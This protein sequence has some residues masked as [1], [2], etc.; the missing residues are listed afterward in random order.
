MLVFLALLI[1]AFA[2]VL[3]LLSC[4]DPT[5]KFDDRTPELQI[6]AHLLAT[7]AYVGVW[8]IHDEDLARMVDAGFR[9]HTNKT[10]HVIEL[11]EDGSCS[12]RTFSYWWPWEDERDRRNRIYEEHYEPYHYRYWCIHD[13]A[14]SGESV[15]WRLMPRYYIKFY[16]LD[17]SDNDA[18]FYFITYDGKDVI[19][20]RRIGDARVRFLKQ[21]E[22]TETTGSVPLA[23]PPE[24][25]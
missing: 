20:N 8:E 17:S 3:D 19:L 21:R 4:I 18:S 24:T 1:L 23:D 5:P 14:T 25:P 13:R 6:P 7:N 15:P 2:G 22:T 10:D 16:N 11:T 12:Y 9:S